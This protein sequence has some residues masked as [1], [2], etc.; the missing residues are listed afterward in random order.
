[1]VEHQGRT[2]RDLVKHVG[3]YPE[4]AYHFVR[5]GLAFAAER[6]HGEETEAHRLLQHYLVVHQLDWNDLIA[7]YHAGQLPEGVVEAIQ[8][9]GGCEKLNRHVSG[10]ELCWGLRDYAILR[11]GMMARSVLESWNVRST[12]DFGKVV[13][14]FIEFDMMQKQESDRIEDFEN[15]FDFQEAFDQ[16]L[17]LGRPEIA[18]DDDE[19]DGPD[20]D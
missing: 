9:A 7:Q 20:E 14:G 5:E 10:R 19:S 17:C 18:T 1:M 3:R 13:F 2:L 12:T 16:P 11:W 6:A 4:E 15:V 8:S